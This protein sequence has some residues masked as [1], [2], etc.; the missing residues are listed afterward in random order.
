MKKQ[1]ISEVSVFEKI[2]S[3]RFSH[4]DSSLDTPSAKK[5]AEGGTCVTTLVREH[6]KLLIKKQLRDAYVNNSFYR[7]LIEKE[8]EIGFNLEHPTLARYV[9]KGEDENG[10]FLLMEY[11]DGTPLDRFLKES[12]DYFKKKS[13]RK[14]FA[15]QL[16]Q[17]L[18]YLHSRHILHLD[19]SPS[20]IMLT[21]IGNDV[22]LL[23]FGYAYT[24]IFDL[25]T[26]HTPLYAAPEQLEGQRPYDERT[27]LYAAGKMLE[28]V[29][30]T[31]TP[32]TRRLLAQDR[33]KRP[34]SANEALC[35]LNSISDNAKKTLLASVLVLLTTFILLYSMS[36][37]KKKEI[38]TIP[39]ISGTATVTATVAGSSSIATSAKVNI[40]DN[41]I[42]GCFSV[43]SSKK[44]EF[45]K[46]NL[47]WDGSAYH[48]E[49]NQTDYPTS[50]N[51]NHVGYFYWTNLTDYQSGNAAY[52]PYAE[53][54]SFSNQSTS[55]KFFCDE[56]N[57]LT[58]EGISGFFALSQSE[59]DY[60]ISSRNN[61]SNLCK[62]GV[63]V[64]AMTDSKKNCLI[65]APDNFSG[66]LKSS[67]TLDELSSLGLVCLP[68][69]GYRDGSSFYGIEQWST[70]W[71]ATPAPSESYRASQL[72]TYADHI[73]TVNGFRSDAHNLRLVR[74][75]Q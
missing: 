61:A 72:E 3:S 68:A 1:Q 52:M 31:S 14:K 45:S 75:A 49:A 55:D 59:W 23:D 47:W 58:V 50:W 12:P 22:K 38:P 71:W 63:T 7:D 42:E 13:T 36:E 41:M 6:G 29:Y 11:I 62:H 5:I 46:G 40:A 21:R 30:G 56:S 60:L 64:D 51:A 19:I 9:Q 8:F 26:G 67:Y 53:Y 10:P 39:N 37:K 73:R 65:I 44:V 2:E 54:Y 34:A 16:L 28:L 66:T 24:S 4:E 70:Y 20:N 57:P 74:L 32:L 17:A 25:S 43:S 15:Q 48:F 69:A 33:D 18:A 35:Q 27:D